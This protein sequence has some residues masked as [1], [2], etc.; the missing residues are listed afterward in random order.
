MS[1]VASRLRRIEKQLRPARRRCSACWAG[2]PIIEIESES[3][4]ADVPTTCTECGRSVMPMV[5][6]L[7]R[8]EV[9]DEH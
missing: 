7:P 5:V 4:I 9:N 2:G 6:V 1:T 8:E 3:E